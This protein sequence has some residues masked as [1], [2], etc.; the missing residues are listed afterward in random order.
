MSVTR[1]RQL[2]PTSQVVYDTGRYRV[3]PRGFICTRITTRSDI[4]FETFGCGIVV[5]LSSAH[6]REEAVGVSIICIPII[7]TRSRHGMTSTMQARPSSVDTGTL[8]ALFHDTT[9]TKTHA[10]QY[11]EFSKRNAAPVGSMTAVNPLHRKPPT[12]A[13]RPLLR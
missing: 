9:T 2:F 4:T 13:P 7:E 6:G 11:M 12:S 5:Q 1:G 10:S 3:N 8:H